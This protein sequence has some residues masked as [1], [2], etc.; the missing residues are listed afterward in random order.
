MAVGIPVILT[1][2]FLAS[3][4]ILGP[5]IGRYWESFDWIFVILLVLMPILFGLSGGYM[6]VFSSKDRIV[7][8]DTQIERTGLR[9]FMIYRGPVLFE[10]LIKVARGSLSV[11]RIEQVD[12]K[13]FEFA[14]KAYEGGPDEI[15]AD[16][17]QR[18]PADRFEDDLEKRLY[19]KTGREWRGPALMVVGALI[20]GLSSCAGD[21]YDEI[22]ADHAWTAEVEAGTLRE[23]IESFDLSPDGSLWIL[24]QSSFGD[25]QDPLSYEVRH[26]TDTGTKVLEFPPFE[27]L[28]PSG[29]PEIGRGQPSGIRLTPE[30]VPRVS[31]FLINS[32]LIWT[33]NQW[34]W[35]RPP[36]QE[37]GP[38]PLEILLAGD[39]GD[40]WEQLVFSESASVS[41]PST[42][43]TETI[44]LGPEMEEYAIVFKAEPR[45]WK[46]ARLRTED[47]RTFLLAFR[48]DP[49]EGQWI[50]I[51]S[52]ILP[53]SESRGLLDYT[54]GPDGSLFALLS[55]WDFCESDVVTFYAGKLTPSEAGG[56]TW[57]ALQYQ[58]DCNE[59][60]DPRDF[61]VDARG[62]IWI[63]GWNQVAAFDEGVFDSPEI[64]NDP[65]ILYTEDNSGYFMSHTLRIGPDERLWSLDMSGDV[66]VS[67]DPDVDELPAPLPDWFAAVSQQFWSWTAFFVI[68]AGIWVL[69]LIVAR[70]EGRLRRTK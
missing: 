23:S 62:R 28:Y 17:R 35:E 11:V 69:G 25:Y 31:M 37:R 63:E 34:E 10:N 36:T 46:L 3:A 54:V 26:I 50:E 33:G 58:Q 14:P 40:Y 21:L 8:S 57:R 66:L 53:L 15:L 61:L 13:N 60:Q 48:E 6:A 55:D 70:N 9:N 5:P 7:I 59:V 67:I 1:V 12:G 42:G 43:S 52:D 64:I 56:W 41:I 22:R 24:V 20:F 45:G 47:R 51:E 16:L 18:I 27:V 19:Q 68:G 2:V 32:A 44:D 29:P 30:G 38:K 4:L 65:E 49:E 39:H